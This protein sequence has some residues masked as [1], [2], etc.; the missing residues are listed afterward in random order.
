MMHPLL[1]FSISP[2]GGN[3]SDDLERGKRKR[4]THC[5]NFLRLQKNEYVGANFKVGFLQTGKSG[6]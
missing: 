2:P 1:P 3:C 5:A 4:I 6:P